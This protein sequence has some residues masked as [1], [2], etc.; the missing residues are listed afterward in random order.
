MKLSGL[1]AQFLYSSS[2]QNLLLV[3]I[4]LFEPEMIYLQMHRYV[5]SQEA[6]EQISLLEN[7]KHLK[8][9]IMI[10]TGSS[11]L[12]IYHGVYRVL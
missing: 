12:C 10:S 9:G 7:D 5:K 6:A 3:A 4:S 2:C 11:L 1:C 8:V